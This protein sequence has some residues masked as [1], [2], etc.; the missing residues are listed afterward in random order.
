MNDLIDFASKI[1]PNIPNLKYCGLRCIHVLIDFQQALSQGLWQNSFDID[2]LQFIDEEKTDLIIKKIKR[3]PKLKYLIEHYDDEANQ[4]FINL[5]SEQEQEELKKEILI[6][7][8]IHVEHK[9]EVENEK[10]IV[11]GDIVTVK[12]DI[13]RMHLI[14]DSDKLDLKDEKVKK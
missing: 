8:K 13:Y 5:F 7:P 10:E 9:V 1:P 6:Y 2:Q 3:V 14:K 4:K 12:L 11:E